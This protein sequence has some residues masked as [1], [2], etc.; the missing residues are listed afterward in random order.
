MLREAATRK[1]NVAEQRLRQ[2]LAQKEDGLRSEKAS[3]ERRWIEAK[4]DHM[5]RLKLRL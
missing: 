4:D 3:K 2:P 5:T 1:G